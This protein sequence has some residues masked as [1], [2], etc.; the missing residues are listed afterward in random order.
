MR[1]IPVVDLKNAAAVRAKAGDRAN[2]HPFESPL[3]PG[4]SDPA[5]IASALTAFCI[6]RATLYIADVDAIEKS[7]ANTEHVENIR[8]TLPECSLLLDE[9]I[10]APD[11]LRHRLADSAIT[12][13][14]GAESLMSEA[15]HCELLAV[16]GASRC[17]LSLDWR[18]NDP[19]GPRELYQSAEHWPAI[20][21]VM[22]LDR[23]GTAWGPDLAK[24]AKVKSMAGT[25]EVLAA[26]GIR[27]L[28]DLRRCRDMGCGAL[29]ASALHDGSITLQSIRYLHQGC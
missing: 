19:I 11:A 8:A 25:R 26:G 12:P 6:G 3:A 4:T 13:V 23:V 16:T 14:I 27:G 21:I 1:V 10:A 24:L 9:G 18:G 29:L 20:V 28:D 17:A 15:Q 22:T 2:Y 7:G 5:A